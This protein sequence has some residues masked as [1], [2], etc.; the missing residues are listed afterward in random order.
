MI[1]FIGCNVR[2]FASEKSRRIHTKNRSSKTKAAYKFTLDNLLKDEFGDAERL[3]GIHCPRCKAKA[4]YVPENI[5]NDPTPL[6]AD[7]SAIRHFAE[8][9][10]R[11]TCYAHRWFALSSDVAQ[12]VTRLS[13]PPPLVFYVQRGVWLPLNHI[14]PSD[15]NFVLHFSEGGMMIKCPDHVAF[16][17]SLDVSSY[18]ANGCTFRGI[19]NLVKCDANL[20]P[21][22]KS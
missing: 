8:S 22:S 7:R 10:C 20:G 14:P 11:N 18:L 6:I 1:K 15:E 17:E 2:F 19:A 13:V 3:T 4:M 16:P 12:K 21:R 5:L 9:E